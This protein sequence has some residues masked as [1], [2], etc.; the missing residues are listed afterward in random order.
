MKV[1][2]SAA[3]NIAIGPMK[4][5]PGLN[6]DVSEKDWARYA[7]GKDNKTPTKAT[8]ALLKDNGGPLTV[9]P[10]DFDLSKMSEAEA[11]KAV[12]DLLDKAKLEAL[13]AGEKRG[14]VRSAIEKQIAKLKAPAKQD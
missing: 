1:T 5:R 12:G 8:A 7:C 6:P 4:F 14:S 13:L 9:E 10:G 11:A 2:N 3:R